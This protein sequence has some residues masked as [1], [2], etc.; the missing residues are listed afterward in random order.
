MNQAYFCREPGAGHKCWLLRKVFT[1]R[2]TY[3]ICFNFAG[4]FFDLLSP[5]LQVCFVA[6][7][8][9]NGEL[10]VHVTRQYSWHTFAFSFG[11]MTTICCRIIY[12]LRFHCHQSD[13]QNVTH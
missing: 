1:I 3:A 13:W 7:F 5:V 6:F 8:Y 11:E 10:M 4:F 9:L 2:R 12:F